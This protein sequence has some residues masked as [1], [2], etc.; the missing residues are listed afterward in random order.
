MKVGVLMS[1]RLD[2]VGEYLAD[3]RALDTAGADSLWIDGGGESPWLILAAIS[4]VTSHATLVAPISVTDRR[5]PT[6]FA[7]RVATLNHLSRGR[8]VLR[9]A[10]AD[11]AA[12][13]DAEA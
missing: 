6:E 9:V 12:P 10:A 2:D 5:S 3:A 1:G 7:A 4:T 8:V 11:G 13:A